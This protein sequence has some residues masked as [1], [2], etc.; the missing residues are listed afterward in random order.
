M[1]TLDTQSLFLDSPYPVK[2]C[3][4]EYTFTF[5]D[6]I[7]TRFDAEISIFKANKP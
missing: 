6:E 4:D 2:Q 1:N 5:L 7:I 3:G